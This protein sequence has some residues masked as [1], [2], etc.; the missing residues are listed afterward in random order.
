MQN[1]QYISILDI[2]SCQIRMLVTTHEEPCRVVAYHSTVSEGIM[3]GVIVDLDAAS[4]ALMQLFDIV[5]EQVDQKITKVY[6]TLSGEGVSALNSHGVVKIR[7]QEVTAHDVEALVSTAQALSLESKE[8]LHVLPMQFKVDNQA[9]IKEPIGMYGVR[10]EGDF[11]IILADQGVCQNFIR[12]LQRVGLA[13]ESFVFTPVGLA[14]VVLNDDER[15]QGVAIVD[16]GAGTTDCCVYVNGALARSI[17][18]PIGGDAITRDIAHRMKI[19]NQL[20]EQL[21]IFLCEKQQIDLD[22]QLQGGVSCGEVLDVIDA[23][24]A[25]IMKLIDRQL[26]EH[27]LKNK[28][29][30]GYVLCGMAARYY[31]LE[32]IIKS[33]LMVDS[34]S[35]GFE[36]G[37]LPSLPQSWLAAAG[38][39]YFRKKNA[40]RSLLA[41]FNKQGVLSKVFHWLETHL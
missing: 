24:Y 32:T 38:I 23:R 3:H 9:G 20:A 31:G 34:R 4:E 10:L 12:C 8:V 37:A 6:C 21:K 7:S 11:H 14:E 13:L 41:G 19:D 29:G 2:G 16:I 17:S 39:L 5:Q 40:S 28:I 33:Q 1:G 22:L 26:I 18:L 36:H 15:Q 25:Q 27:G 30:R 35:G